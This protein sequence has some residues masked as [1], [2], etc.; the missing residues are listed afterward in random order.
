MEQSSNLSWFVRLPHT[1][2]D[3]Y[4][5]IQDASKLKLLYTFD[6]SSQP[7]LPAKALQG[8]MPRLIAADFSF[9]T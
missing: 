2:K 8:Q 6:T 5:N 7:A 9:A 3:S 1:C 4:G